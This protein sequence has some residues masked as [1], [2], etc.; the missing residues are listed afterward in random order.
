MKARSGSRSD[1]PPLHGTHA[2]TRSQGGSARRKLHGKTW[3]TAAGR[4]SLKVRSQ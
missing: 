2:S 1:L 3:S 4:S